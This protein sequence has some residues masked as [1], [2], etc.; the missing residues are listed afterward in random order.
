M[1]AL[2]RTILL[3]TLPVLFSI[4]SIAQE[5]L[6]LPKGLAPHEIDLIPA[7]QA[8]R[9]GIDRGINTPP[10][11]PVRTMGEWE[12]VQTLCVAWQAFPTIL[13]QIVRHAKEE[14][15]VLIICAS[16]GSNSQSSITGYLLASN[17]GGPP[18]ANMNNISFQTAATNSIWIRDYGPETM[19]FNEVDS[20][21]LLDWIYNRPRPLDDAISDVIGNAKNISVFSTTQAPNDLV[22]TGGNFMADG[23]GTAFSS[24]L[25]IEENGSSGQYNQTVRTPAQIDAMMGTWMG[26]NAGRY[27]KMS[28]LPYDGIHHIDMH[29]KLLDEETLLIGQFP[30]GVSDGPQI[31]ANIQYIQNNYTSVFGTPYEIVR[32]PMIPSTTGAYPPSGNYRTYAN[33]IFI[34]KTVLVPTYRQQYDTTGLRILRETLPGYRVIGIDCD[35]TDGNI[36]AQSGAIHCITKA[37]GVS[38]P[39]LIRHQRLRDTNDPFDPYPVEAYIRHKSGVASAQLLW[40]TD[41]AA[42]FNTVPMVPSAG[43]EWNAQIPAQPVGST[44]FYYIHATAI[45]GKQLSRPIVAPTGTWQFDV[46]PGGAVGTPVSIKMLLEG[47]YDAVGGS[48]RD[49]L[50]VQGL[51]PLQEPYTALGYTMIGGSGSNTSNAVLSVSGNNAI[52]DWVLVELRSANTPASII[53]TRTGLLQRDG[54][55]IAPNGGTIVFDVAAGNYYVSVRHRNHLGCMTATPVA[56]YNPPV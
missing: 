27:V 36:I 43:N 56:L 23:F 12:E 32:I 35:N 16:S 4:A 22:H 14:C 8:S 47:A 51:V 26:I 50:R 30:S 19:Y 6:I 13:K 28:T 20:L 46:I 5:D 1:P 53:R 25:V 45:N 10:P 17:A 44:I 18:L 49:D 48:M 11:V 24:N 40:T 37:I 2:L 54:D 15:E 39:L 31:E 34:N 29:M 7:Y 38:D 33:N 42:G 3:L 21:V 9:A 41:T 55:V 52:V